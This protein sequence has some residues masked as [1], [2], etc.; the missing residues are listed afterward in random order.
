MSLLTVSV[1][2]AGVIAA[3]GGTPPVPV[4]LPPGPAVAGDVGWEA[5]DVWRAVLDAVGA[6]LRASAVAPTGLALTAAA[7]TT[8]VWDAESLGAARPVVPLPYGEALTVVRNSEPHTWALL[9][10]GRCAVGDLP[11]YL[12]ARMT[13]GV[14]QVAADPV[15]LPPQL[16]DDLP[17]GTLPAAADPWPGPGRIRTDPGAFAGLDLPVVA[18]AAV[19]DA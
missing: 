14:W 19:A 8:A 1:G 10:S 13:R 7:P 16:A 11:G 17:D 12:V 18:F 15:T 2:R 4:L 5:A 3:I 9:L 6:A